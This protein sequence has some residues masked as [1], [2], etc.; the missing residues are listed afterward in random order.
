MVRIRLR[1]TGL[2]NQSTYR[3]MAA[4]KESPR[5]G[6]FLEILGSYNPRTNPSTVEVKE[7]RVYDWMSKG[8]QPSESVVQIFNSVGL[9]DRYARFKKGESKEV[10]LAEAKTAYEKHASSG[11][12]E[13]VAVEEK[14]S[15]VKKG[16]KEKAAATTTET[17]KAEK[18]AEKVESAPAETVEK[19][20]TA[21]AESAKEEAV[22]EEVVEKVEPTPVATLEKEE[23]SQ[24][25]SVKEETVSAEVVEKTES[26]PVKEKT[27]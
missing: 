4:E 6:R 24:A 22:P 2:K 23:T 16:G 12:A 8:A 7:E 14:K 5:D 1:R 11:K 13:K 25:E 18:K 10:L 21:P 27:E 19:E 20:A 15:A 9:M 26:A 3:I 17:P